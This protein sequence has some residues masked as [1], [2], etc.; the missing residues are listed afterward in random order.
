M[1]GMPDKIKG[2]SVTA[3]IVLKNVSPFPKDIEKSLKDEIV[4]I[5]ESLVGRFA[6]PKNII[7][8][9]DLP[10]T[11][12]GKLVRR[13]IKA[14]ALGENIGNQDVSTIENPE[15]LKCIIS[16]KYY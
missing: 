4:K 12:T 10:R 7:F 5:V 13:V 6:C 11:R 15:S 1:I 3:Y 2:E 8:V 9:E 14:K 16:T